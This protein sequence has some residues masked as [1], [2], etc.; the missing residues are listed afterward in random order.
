MSEQNV[1]GEFESKNLL[2]EYGLRVTREAVVYSVEEAVNE[3][4]KLGFPVV[5][6]ITGSQFTHKTELNGV[7]LNL[8]DSASVKAA[9]DELFSRFSKPVPLLVSEQIESSREFIAGVARTAD[10]GLTLVFGVG[11][12]FA[13]EL[14]D[15]VFRLLPASR[16]EIFSMYGDLSLSSLLGPVRGEP[17]VDLESLTETLWAISSCALERDD[18]CSIDVNPILISGGYPIAVDALVELYG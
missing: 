6:K 2:S 15:V 10:Y 14:N 1:L 4:N 3:A 8:I 11:G 9:A 7:K 16:S 18:I 17:K 12:I 5:I 13:E